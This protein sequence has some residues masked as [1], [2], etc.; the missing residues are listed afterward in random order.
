MPEPLTGWVIAEHTASK[1]RFYLA[2]AFKDD[3][4]T[5]QV[6]THT[7][8]TGLRQRLPRGLRCVP[9]STNEHEVVEVW[10]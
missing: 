5:G 2:R 7:T 10:T 9:S 3:E 1:P 8:L 4:P 6:L